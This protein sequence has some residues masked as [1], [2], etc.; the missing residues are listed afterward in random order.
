LGLTG[1]SAGAGL[2]WVG[3]DWKPSFPWSYGWFVENQNETI[4]SVAGAFF[5]CNNCPRALHYSNPNIPFLNSAVPSGTA[6]AF[7]ARTAA[8]LAPVVS[9][10]RNPV[11]TGLI[12]R[13]GFEALPIP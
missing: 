3:I 1:I 12:F 4:M 8:F 11:L 2:P 10:F 7:N 6:T 5:T 13:A 9:E